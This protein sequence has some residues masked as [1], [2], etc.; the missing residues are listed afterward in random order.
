[1]L[2]FDL[3]SDALVN[4]TKIHVLVVYDYDTKQSSTYVGND[5]RKG[6]EQLQNADCICGHNIINFDIPCIK[7]FYPWFQP[8][9]VRD[10]LVWS[11]VVYPDIVDI[12]LLNY[13]KWGMPKDLI[14]THKLK[15]WGYRLG[16]YKG[17]ITNWEICTPE[18]IAYCEQDVV[19]TTKVYEKLLSKELSEEC[20]ELEHEVATIIQKQVEYGFLFDIK[21]AEQLY[22]TL[23]RKREEL[24]EK[25]QEVFKPWEVVDRIL[26]PKRDNKAKGYLTGVPVEIKKTVV[27]NPASRQHIIY[28]L[29]LRYKWKPIEFTESGQPQMDE[30]VLGKLPYPEAKLLSTYFM[31]NKRIGQLAE[32]GKA[33]LKYIQKDGRIHGE[34]FTNGCVTGRMSHNKPN[35]AQVPAVQVDDSNTVLKGL[36]GLYGWE[37]RELFIVPPDRKL[38]GCDAAAL[39]LRCLAHYMFPYDKGA[40]GEAAVHGKKKLGTDIHTLNMK[41]LEITSRDIAKT[42]F[43][44][45]IYGGGDYKLGY[46]IIP[47]RPEAVTRSAGKQSRAKFL[48]NI[49]ALG[50]LTKAV[51]TLAKERG[52][53]FGLDKRHLKIRSDYK[54][55]NTLLQGAGAVVMKKAL[56]IL[57]HALVDDMKL[58]FG[59]DFAFV[60]NIHDEIQTECKPE[61]AETIG[62]A[63]VEAIRK[64]GEYFNFKCPLDGEFKIGNNWAETH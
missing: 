60:G 53:L 17:E 15:A 39:E 44:A 32:G 24:T 13:Q 28:Q 11:R 42:W 36:E 5:V 40:Y 64:A 52:Y 3:E 34:V 21:K 25:L 62:K 48:K 9:Q 14:G 18:M 20:L 46:L 31:I 23:L 37:C 51:K 2:L 58:E 59:R 16:D 19:V 41:A 45:F 50:S 29:Q 30:K 47:N 55:L 10:T 33:W 35:I 43:Y 27:F 38:V 56:V 12:D 63:A 1:L 4:Y 8:K 26:I 57:Y 61:L 7:K 6:I 49:P 22:V 54:A